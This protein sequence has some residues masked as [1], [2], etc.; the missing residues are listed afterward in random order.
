MLLKGVKVLDLSNLLPGPMCSLFLADLGAD[1]VKI[2]SLD[3]DLM[4]KLDNVDG[5]SPYFSALNRNKKSIAINLKTIEGKKI[6]IELA[7]DADVII[8]GFRPGKIDSLGIGYANVKKINPKVI[9]CSISGYGQQGAYKSKAGHDIN[10]A[11]LSGLLDSLSQ[12]PFVPGIQIADIGSAMTSALSIMAALFYREKSGKG[13]YIDVSVFHSSLSLIGIYISH[14]SLSK[15]RKTVL[16]GSKPC[17]SLYETKD[18]K[19]ASFGAI[20]GK[21]WK[22]FCNSVERNDLISKQFDESPVILQEMRQLFKSKTL[23]E[24]VNLGKERDFC[25]E[26]LS[27]LDKVDDF[28]RNRKIFMRLDN[29]KQVAMPVVFSSVKGLNYSKAPKLGEHTSRILS[30][31]GYGNKAIQKLRDAKVIL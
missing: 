1:V 25:I 22:S 27:R 2:E 7:K 21:F 6:F 24:W 30:N 4:R 15:K 19:Y 23:N 13:N 26:P 14:Q 18:G 20:E 11:A 5:K 16:S 8:E 12:K 29:M 10:Y 9:F 17:Y 31:I 28:V 3:G